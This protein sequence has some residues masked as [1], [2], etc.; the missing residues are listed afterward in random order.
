MFEGCLG[1]KMD[2]YMDERVEQPASM[3]CGG[4]EEGRK[5]VGIERLMFLFFSCPDL[6]VG[7]KANNE[8]NRNKG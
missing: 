4:E 8:R 7:N 5:F 6:G 2:I 1:L 3:G